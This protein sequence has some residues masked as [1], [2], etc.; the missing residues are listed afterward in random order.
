MQLKTV[1]FYLVRKAW[2]LFAATLV[3]LAVLIS[4]LK[5]TLPYANDYKQN[6]EQ[7]LFEQYGVDIAIGSISASWQGSGPALVLEKLSFTDNQTS[8]IALDIDNTSLQLNL[9]ETL[10]TWQLS[11]NYFVISGLSANIDSSRFNAT[12]E[13]EFEQKALLEGLFLG[14]TGHFEVKDSRLDIKL[15]DGKTRSLLVDS[16][17]WQNQDSEHRGFGSIAI[18]GIS[19]GEFTANLALAGDAFDEVTGRI[20]F[21]AKGVDIANWLEPWLDKNKT[22]VSTDFNASSWLTIAKGKLTSAVVK[23]HPSFIRWQ[24]NRIKQELSLV[25]AEALV[26]FDEQ[27]NWEVEASPWRFSHGGREYDS[28]KWQAH[29]TNGYNEI[30]LQSLD[31]SLVHE[32][33]DFSNEE[34][35]QAVVN[36]QPSGIISHAKV[37]WG[38]KKPWSA[39]ASIEQLGWQNINGVPGAQHLSATVYA[40]PQAARVEIK[41]ENDHLLTGA[42]FSKA[43]SYD[44]LHATL[45]FHE[46]DEGWQLISRDLW[47]ANHELTV[48]GELGVDLHDANHF[49][50]YAEVRGGSGENAANYFPITVMNANLIAYLKGAIKAGKHQQSQVLLSGQL[51]DFPF[52]NTSGQFEV[53]SELDAVEFAFAPKW[54]AVKEA[55]VHLDF[56]DEAMTITATDGQLLNQTIQ[57]PVVVRIEDLKNADELYVDINTETDSSTL[58]AFFAQTPLAKH[59]D[60]VFGVVKPKGKVNG[61]VLLTVDLVDGGVTATGNVD[62]EGN[63]IEL[64]QPGMRLDSMSGQLSFVNEKLDMSGLTGLWRTMPIEVA[65][66]ANSDEKEYRVKINA[67]LVANAQELELI[68]GGLTKGFVQGQSNIDTTV[69]LVFGQS[70]FSY[71]A[72]SGSALEGIELQLPAPFTKQKEQ[73][74]QLSVQVKGDNISNLITANLGE[75]LYFNGI[76]D[77]SNGKLSNASLIV[78][79]KNRGLVGEQFN[80][81]VTQTDLQLEPWF[82]FLNRLIDLSSKSAQSSILPPFS[83][84]TA[85]I[86]RLDVGVLP[87]S[88]VQLSL[89]PDPDGQLAIVTAKELR[90][91]VTLPRT[92]SSRPI[93]AVI[94]YLRLTPKESDETE[95]VNSDNGERIQWLTS[96]PAIDVKCADC[97]IKQYQLDKLTMSLFGD[98]RQLVVPELVVDKGEHVLRGNATWTQG[99]A[100]FQGK[101]ESQDIG[102]LFDELELTSTV[103]DSNAEVEFALNWLGAPYDVDLATLDGD[104][105]WSL[106]EGHLAEISDGGARVFSLLSLDSLVRKLKL[107]F[108]DVFSKGFFYNQFSGTMQL[109]SGIAYTQD[110][111]LDGVP[112]DLAIQGHANLIS[113]EIDYDL[114]VAPQVTSS[115]PVIVA[116]MV[117]PV[118]GLAALAIDKVIHS[119]RVISE[120]KFKVTGTMDEPHVVEINRTSRE[121]E[122]PQAALS[123]PPEQRLDDEMV[124]ND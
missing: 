42:L 100:D 62:F 14:E 6:I 52:S 21:S 44:Q 31:L 22:S 112:A 69:E 19:Q 117:N 38:Q 124:L 16:L 79:N 66:A 35:I 15:P 40:K 111:K 12:S 73:P 53:R 72:N 106:G 87:F 83:Q 8:P 63:Q 55:K 81:M 93:S 59:L 70:G 118:S 29:Q 90:A 113:K 48:A 121:V 67:M 26:T 39:F 65:L 78:G 46:R 25:S 85:Q 110:T 17:L 101:L 60:P 102:S 109:K 68:S 114:A 1:T 9:F 10:K 51:S 36:L 96:V 47:F 98:G 24:E 71:T 108:R 32:L 18:P 76:L 34:A 123:K 58:P 119:A 95:E 23:W 88:E 77:N 92:G 115:L 49:A 103:K 13:T 57:Q 2:Q 54:P 41:G 56:T 27:Q 28:I 94:D 120:I 3:L 4:A 37:A 86:E 20:H 104:V 74:Q 75:Q 80:V 84:L 89:Q 82:P 97:K 43:M 61:D 5:Y 99:R 105:K 91:K 45:E 30:W 11:S 122:L 64:T 107:D 116:W 7:L 50:L 33:V